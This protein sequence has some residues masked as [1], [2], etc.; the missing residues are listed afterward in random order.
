MLDSTQKR[1]GVEGLHQERHHSCFHRPD[2]RL[3]NIVARD[4]DDRYVTPVKSEGLLEFE[5]SEVRIDV[6]DH[7]T[8][9]GRDR[10]VSQELLCGRECL[11]SPPS[12]LDQQFQRFSHGDVVVNDEH[13]WSGIRH[14][15]D[16]N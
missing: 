8:R 6:K 9:A 16:L 7:A 13:D 10:W 5:T 11:R 2:R 15:H 12:G 3:P 1:I 14:R 4:E